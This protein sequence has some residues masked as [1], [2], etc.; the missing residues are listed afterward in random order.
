[1][2][3]SLAIITAL[4]LS[5]CSSIPYIEPVPDSPPPVVDKGVMSKDQIVMFSKDEKACRAIQQK[6]MPTS[7]FEAL[8]APDVHKYEAKREAK[9]T[10]IMRQCL[11]NRGHNVIY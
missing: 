9:A 10:A 3:Y 11:T 7:L 4:S 2:K 8:A 5:A 6:S 1:M